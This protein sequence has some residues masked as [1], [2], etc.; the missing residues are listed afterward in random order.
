MNLF[1]GPQNPSA[2]S[3]SAQQFAAELLARWPAAKVE[4]L[5]DPSDP[6]L[7]R[8]AFHGSDGPVEGGLAR[9]GRTLVLEYGSPRDLAAVVV[10]FRRFSPAPEDLV[11][12]NEGGGAY[13][14]ITSGTG[15][16]E[17]AATLS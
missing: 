6:E 2:W 4:L 5:E 14:V 9:T 13:A 17:V 10:W 8:F 7:L 16:D 11:M 15:P 3:V 12:V 1:V